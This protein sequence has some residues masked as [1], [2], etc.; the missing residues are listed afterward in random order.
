[1]LYWDYIGIMEKKMETVGI[2]VVVFW[3]LP[4]LSNSWIISTIWLYIALNGTPNIDCYWWGQYPNYKI[5]KGLG[6]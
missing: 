5:D 4:P 3:V 6:A 2:M 1:M